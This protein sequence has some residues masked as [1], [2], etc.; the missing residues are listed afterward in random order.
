[1]VDKCCYRYRIYWHMRLPYVTRARQMTVSRGGTFSKWI[2]FIRWSVRHTNFA[3]NLRQGGTI[4]EAGLIAKG[5]LMPVD[6]VPMVRSEHLTCG[7]L[8]F[9]PC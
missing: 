4:C 1:M 3:A 8:L 7:S 9:L 5:V 6:T 2:Y